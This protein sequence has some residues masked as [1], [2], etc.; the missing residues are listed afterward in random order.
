MQIWF[1]GVARDFLPR[2]NFQC[3]F[4]FSVCIPPCAITCI[5]IC[6][7]GKDHV[8]CVTV[9]WIMATQTYPA[10]TMSNRYNQLDD[11]GYSTKEDGWCDG[12]KTVLVSLTRAWE[13]YCKCR[14]IGLIPN[15]KP[16]FLGFKKKKFAPKITANLPE[17]CGWKGVEGIQLFK[18]G[19]YIYRY[20]YTHTHTHTHTH[21]QWKRSVICNLKKS[22]YNFNWSLMVEATHLLLLQWYLIRKRWKTI[23][24]QY[25][26]YIEKENT[27]WKPSPFMIVGW[28][29]CR[30][31]F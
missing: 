16:D 28:K 3:R 12:V 17:W 21:T 19:V 25:S 10:C 14:Q 15:A 1:H 20:R 29:W 2:V 8:L 22:H 13:P 9:W 5:N 30:M 6:S 31:K 24:M 18:C 11:F 23:P 4:S 7:H 26:F 27:M